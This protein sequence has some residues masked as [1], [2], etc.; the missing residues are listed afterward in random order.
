MPSVS[1][2]PIYIM[3]EYYIN[4]LTNDSLSKSI[5]YQKS[6]AILNVQNTNCTG[7]T[8]LNGHWFFRKRTHRLETARGHDSKDGVGTG[9]SELTEAVLRHHTKR[10][11]GL[12]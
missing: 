10:D 1:P 2:M 12:Q 9:A 5:S 8:Y 3:V 4:G 11:G 6:S 7:S